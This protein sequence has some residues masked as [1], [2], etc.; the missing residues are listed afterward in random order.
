MVEEDNNAVRQND[1]RGDFPKISRKGP[2]NTSANGQILGRTR[3]PKRPPTD[4]IKFVRK[5]S[6]GVQYWHRAIQLHDARRRRGTS[7]KVSEIRTR[8]EEV[9]WQEHIG[10]L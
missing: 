4:H 3:P 1:N 7:S 9:V 6:I 5:E 8:L 2:M 10:P